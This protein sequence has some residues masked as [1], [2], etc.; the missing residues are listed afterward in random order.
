LRGAGAAGVITKPDA[1]V[2][3]EAERLWRT[4]Q[5]MLR[6]TL[7]QVESA[8]LPQASALPLL[9]AAAAAGVEAADSNELLR[10]M[11]EIALR[12][13]DLFERHVGKLAE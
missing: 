9:H 6:M 2:L 5:G 10:K 4:I 7:G 1:A 8:A 12:V 11:G 13:R 3:I